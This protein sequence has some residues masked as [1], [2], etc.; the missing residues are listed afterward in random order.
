M[1]PWLAV[2]RSWRAATTPPPLAMALLRCLELEPP[3]RAGLLQPRVMMRR[4]FEGSP[5]CPTLFCN[6]SAYDR[7]E[8]SA[9]HDVVDE[10]TAAA[11]TASSAP[12]P[13]GPLVERFHLDELP[14][15][16]AEPA[17]ERRPRR[18]ATARYAREHSGGTVQSARVG[19]ARGR[20]GAAAATT[21]GAPRGPTQAR[22]LLDPLPLHELPPRV[23]QY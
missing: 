2:W 18:R 20:R 7:A 6:P 11:P 5:K 16:R 3:R 1:L 17:A 19:T 9:P 15:P 8:P 12:A 14:L 10:P 22:A 21:S 23:W 4:G 13:A